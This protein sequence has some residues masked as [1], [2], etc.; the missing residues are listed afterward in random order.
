MPRNVLPHGSWPSPISPA[1]LVRSGGV[2]A[3]PRSDGE[4]VYFL[5]TREE[6]GGRV[7]LS[8][9]AADGTTVDVSPEW[10]SV[11]SRVH[12]YGGGAWTVRDGIVL[13]IDFTTQQ[14][15]RLDGEPRPLTPG[16]DE[17]A[18]RWSA[19][20][21]DPVRSVCFVVREDH[22][23]PGA[24]PLNE[25]V[26]VPLEPAEPGFGTVVVPGR[27]RELPRTP[28]DDA[29]DVALPDFVMD[30]ALSP[31]G[32]RLAFVQWSHP[33]MPWDDAAVVVASLDDNGDAV[34]SRTVAG[35]EGVAATE[36]VWLD[37]TRLAFLADP[38]G[39]AVP[40]VLD[41]EGAAPATA[42]VPGGSEYGSAAWTLRTRAMT[43]LPD[44]RLA[45]L[46]LVDGV[47][48]L[49]VVDPDSPGKPLD[50]DA[51]IVDVDGLGPHPRGVVCHAGLSDLGLTT[52]VV[53]VGDG[54]L[55]VVDAHGDAPDPAYIPTAEPVTWKG[56]DGQAVHGFLYR[57]TH[58]EVEGP[59]DELP[60]L[61]V[62]A[63]GGPTSATTTVPR[64]SISFFTSRGIA[65][66]DVN[67]SGSTGY[68]K[69]YRD[70]LRGTWGLA[71]I[72]DCV[73]G[74]RHLAETGVVDGSRLGVRGG[75]AGGF[76]VLA[77]LAFHDV[78]SAG[79][80]YFG[81]ADLSLLA[82]E[83]HKFESRYLD[84]LVGPFPAARSTYDERSPLHH[85]DGIR[86]PLLLLQGE[87]DHVVPPSQAEVMTRALEADGLPVALAMFP[88]EGHGFREPAAIIRAA[89]LELS[90]LGQVWGFTPA[91]DPEQVVIRN[92]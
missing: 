17:A 59:E 43:R 72:E 67:Y 4:D 75:S 60:P 38:D 3:D 36:P 33:S 45:V 7:I 11:R 46:R 13:A 65:V 49:T 35:G 52:S 51:R 37:G 18:V 12:E 54:S 69:A 91:G 79:V 88:G 41:L 47:G 86:V 71:D 81:V 82:E 66:L 61:M 87:E 29:G 70:R 55:T 53:D 15:W 92:F 21:I 23:D 58:A 76:V 90:F 77:A 31:D 30:P 8:R 78:F 2:P 28:E 62:V 39:W 14:L 27:R 74:A 63:H 26:R 83:T 44:G 1:E 5:H 19:P 24:E 16:S 48:R 9:R 89:E 6:S 64:P 34:D 84:G 50:L 10:M 22:R 56:Y 80:S 25:I 73:A 20:E 85:V 40:H 42:L 68:G 57:P 32:N